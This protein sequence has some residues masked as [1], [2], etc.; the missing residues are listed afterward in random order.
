MKLLKGSGINELMVYDGKTYTLRKAN[1]RGGFGLKADEK[2]QGI[3]EVSSEDANVVRSEKIIRNG[4]L[5]ILRDG[6][7]YNAQGAQL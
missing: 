6:K 1:G 3:K 7:S 4:Q 5:I 2:P